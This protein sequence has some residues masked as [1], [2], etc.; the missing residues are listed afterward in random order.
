MEEYCEILDKNIYKIDNK[1]IDS[2]F[3]DVLLCIWMTGG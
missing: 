3:N 2:G 1:I